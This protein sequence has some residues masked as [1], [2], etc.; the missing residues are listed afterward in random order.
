MRS[1][2]FF[3]I[4]LAALAWF[5][6]PALAQAC[7]GSAKGNVGEVFVAT[8]P[9]GD[10]ATWI[11]ERVE[12]EGLETDHFARPSLMLDFPFARGA[13][14]GPEAAI[15]SIT[16]FS[17]PDV[18]RAPDLS[19]VSVEA[20]LDGRVITWRG[21]EAGK[22][23]SLLAQAL[24]QQWPKMLTI[25]LKKAGAGDKLA[26][27]AFDLTARTVAERLAGEALAS[28]VCPG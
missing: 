5:A 11:V 2:V 15:V 28:R 14:A 16:R 6:A 27:A 8:N 25:T 3:A 23:D 13:L 9:A 22:G 17:D 7:E 20:R 10:T 24:R 1:A 21:S 19:E 12:G 18:G 26:E 4:W